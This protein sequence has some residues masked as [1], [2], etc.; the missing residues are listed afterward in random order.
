MLA[1]AKAVTT[2]ESQGDLNSP[3]LYHYRLFRGPTSRL[4]RISAQMLQHSMTCCGPPTFLSSRL[5]LRS[6]LQTVAV[7][8]LN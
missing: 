6:G 2:Q 7:R 8:T 4:S 3:T 5:V 1:P